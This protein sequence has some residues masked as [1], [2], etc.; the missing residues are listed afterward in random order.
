MKSLLLVTALNISILNISFA[1]EVEHNYLVGPQYADCDSL[2]ITGLS[3]SE[4]IKKI[5]TSK[6]RFNQTFKLTRKQGLQSGEYYSCDNAQGYLVIIYDGNE[7]LFDNVE[8]EIWDELIASS[9][10]EDMFFRI[11]KHYNPAP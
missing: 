1:Q 9:D 8:K 7:V 3:S 5:R 4:C 2:E 10:P 11:R 6:F